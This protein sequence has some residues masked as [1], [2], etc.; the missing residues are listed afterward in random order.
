MDGE[1][2]VG[3]YKLLTFGMGSYCIAQATVCDWV[4]LLYNT[5]WRNSVNQLYFNFFFKGKNEL[6]LFKKLVLVSVSE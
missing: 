3:R 1:S 2:G 4:T 6:S 5:N